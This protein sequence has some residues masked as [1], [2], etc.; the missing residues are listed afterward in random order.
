MCDKYFPKTLHRSFLTYRET[1]QGLLEAGMFLTLD[2]VCR[3]VF[4]V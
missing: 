2:A 1:K 4:S 3:S